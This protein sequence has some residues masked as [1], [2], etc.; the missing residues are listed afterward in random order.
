M[1]FCPICRRDDFG[2]VLRDS[3]LRCPVCELRGAA[4]N[5]AN[6]FAD[7]VVG[8][9]DPKSK[10]AAHCGAALLRVA[11]NVWEGTLGALRQAE[12]G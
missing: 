10:Y 11:Q 5:A 3:N 2:V 8:R 7:A 4:R 1:I 9:D 6:A 12:K